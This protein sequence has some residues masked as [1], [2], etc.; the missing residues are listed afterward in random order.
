M[1]V[2]QAGHPG[3]GRLWLG[4]LGQ[5]G[6]ALALQLSG[7]P[8]PAR[9]PLSQPPSL[10]S[11]GPHIRAGASVRA[12]IVSLHFPCRAFLPS[13]PAPVTSLTDLGAQVTP[14]KGSSR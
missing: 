14:F 7:N 4:A 3:H 5:G 2:Y 6:P 1:T 13:S 11:W 8:A 10:S 9:A 12:R